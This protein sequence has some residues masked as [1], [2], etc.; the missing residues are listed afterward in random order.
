MR[1]AS[2]TCTRMSQRRHERRLHAQHRDGNL[3]F[4]Q[5]ANGDVAAR[6]VATQTAPVHTTAMR[7]FA[8]QP[9]NVE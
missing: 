4:N 3:M 8:S 7:G 2:Y 5:Y 1:T 9:K 6:L